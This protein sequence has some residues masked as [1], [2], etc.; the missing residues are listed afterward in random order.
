MDLTGGKG[1]HLVL[2][3]LGGV[4]WPKNYRL[5]TLGGRLVYF[6]TSSFAPG[7]RRSWWARFRGMVMLPL[8]TPLKLMND[9]KAVMGINLQR[10]WAQSDTLRPW[11]KQI[12]AWYDEA[13]FRPKIDRTFSFSEA[14]AAHHYLQDRQN[15]GKVL[16][17]P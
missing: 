8:Y 11:M 7:K 1:V 12:V 14:A 4:H 16:L 2:D 3:P 15:I 9:N 6:G 13:L 5:L 10:M 17:L